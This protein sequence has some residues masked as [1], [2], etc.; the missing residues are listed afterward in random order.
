MEWIVGMAVVAGPVAAH[1]ALEEAVVAV[2]VEAAASAHS[3]AAEAGAN[4]CSLA[5]LRS[6]SSERLA[7]PDSCHSWCVVDTTAVA[8]VV[9]RAAKVM[10]VLAVYHSR[11]YG[12]VKALVEPEPAT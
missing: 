5:I 8:L 7:I 1:T 10:T 11:K 2:A 4:T 12:A 9:D 3:A 6:R